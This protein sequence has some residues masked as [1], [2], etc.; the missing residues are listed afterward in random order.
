MA[1]RLAPDLR[2]RIVTR[3]RDLGDGA[4]YPGVATGSWTTVEGIEVLYLPTRDQRPGRMT[5]LLREASPSALYLNSAFS[6]RFTL[7]PL[8]ARRLADRHLPLVVAPRG[9]FAPAALALRAGPKAIYLAAMRASGLLDGAVWQASSPQERDD[10]GR[11]MGAEVDVR[12]APDLTAAV[13]AA[14][15]QR[16]PK[17]PGVVRIVFLGRISPMKNLDGFLRMLASGPPGVDFAIHGPI[18]DVRHWAEC[19]RLM[20]VLPDGVS[21]IYGGQVTPEDV[22]SLLAAA[23]ALVLPSHGENF[24]HVV[25]EALAAACP[26]LVSDRT[27]WA[28]VAK[29]GAGWLLPVDDGPGWHA[30]LAALVA[31]SE[32]DHAALRARAHALAC[33]RDA[34]PAP[35]AANRAL[36]A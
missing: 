30:S 36:F 1:L 20:T 21:A 12:V 3:D 13:P 26:V 16:A 24:G 25:A 10:V 34:D 7:L 33:T 6:R 9:E 2:F 35:I 32:E 15:P 23:D 27:P 18:E 11:A 22:P 28:S 8:A 14:P 17:R 19:R 29:A 31:M 5:A 4:P